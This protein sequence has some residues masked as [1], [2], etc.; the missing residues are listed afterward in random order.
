MRVIQGII[1]HDVIGR[2]KIVLDQLR[3]G[4][5][6]LGFSA[7]MKDHPDIFMELFVS[8]S[9][10]KLS[11]TKLISVLQF[12]TDMSDD[13]KNVQRYL[14][15]F[16]QNAEIEMLENF[17]HFV[18]GS[19]RLPKFGLGRIKVK[20]ENVPSVFASTCLLTLTLPSCFENEE[21]FSA[22]FTAVLASRGKSFNCV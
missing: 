22:S 20:F 2:P 7:K 11:A 16:L 9:E 4:L 17:V 1:I 5:A 6:S 21:S 12:P 15:H 19:N 13:E 14:N 10:N 3:E 8:S 18:T